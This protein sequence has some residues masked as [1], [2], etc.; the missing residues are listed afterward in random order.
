MKLIDRDELVRILNKRREFYCD[1]TPDSFN[2]LSYPDKCRVDMLD[3]C[4][5]DAFNIPSKSFDSVIEDIKAEIGARVFDIQATSD[6]Y[7][8]GVDDVMDIVDEIIDNHISGKEN[9]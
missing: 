8:D 2:K 3:T 1:N 7:F 9:E 6:K 5:S 4:I